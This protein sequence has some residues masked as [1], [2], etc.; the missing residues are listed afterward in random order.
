MD[1][2][3]PTPAEFEA[4]TQHVAWVRRLAYQLVRD[5]GVADDLAQDACLA[6]LEGRRREERAD[7]RGPLRDW[8][9]AV[10]R[11]G[12]RL[13]WRR[14]ERRNE[15][16]RA[17]AQL[18]SQPSTAELVERVA[19]HR[20][21]VDAVLALD[22]PYRA[23]L[24]QRYFEELSPTAIASRT[25]V[26]LATV[27][28]RLQRGIAQLRATLGGADGRASGLHALVPFLALPP[29]AP[30]PTALVVG[31]PL[32]GFFAMNAL[33]KL[34]LLAVAVVGGLVSFWPEEPPSAPATGPVVSDAATELKT[35]AVLEQGATR[36]TSRAEA[37]PMPTV[38]DVAA[39]PTVGIAASDAVVADAPRT[40]D[41][42][43][44]VLGARA[45]TLSGIALAFEP[46]DGGA[47]IE[48]MSG[49]GGTFALRGLQ[50]GG[51]I[52]AAGERYVTLFSAHASQQFGDAELVV[53]VAPRVVLGGCVVDVAGRP[54]ADALV[55]VRAPEGFRARFE[56]VL[57]HSGGLEVSTQTDDAGRFTLD[58]P[59]L[60]DGALVASH[61]RYVEARRPLP[62]TDQTELRLTLERPSLD[63]RTLVGVVLDA[64]GRPAAGARVVFG[65][66]GTSTAEDG[67]FGIDLDDER[68]PNRRASQM[69]FE[70]LRVVAIKPGHLPAQLE[71]ARDDATGQAV[72][73]AS[74]VLH[75]GGPP[76]EIVGRV[77]DSAGEPLPGVA[78]WVRDESVLEFGS[79]GPRSIEATVGDRAPNWE[80]PRT[81]SDGRFVLSGLVD[82][83]YVVAAHDA[84][85]LL[86][87]EREVRAGSSSVTLVLD[88]G[89][90]WRR[91]AGKVVDR[92]GRP[93]SGVHLRP[94]TDALFLR[95]QGR[96]VSTNHAGQP[97]STETDAEGKFELENMPRELVY[98]RID[99]DDVVSEDW[100]RR[101]EGGLAA[102]SNGRVEELEVV[103]RLRVR[104]QV[105][106][107]DPAEADAVR[108][109]DADG[110]A[111]VIN[112]IQAG[113][114]SEREVFPLV[115]GRSDVLTVDDSAA[116]LVL[117]REGQEVRR[118]P[119][120]LQRG[121]LNRVDA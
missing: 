13:E 53:V 120:A 32:I 36:T 100:G 41:V 97:R 69:G 117:E 119:L 112:L 45:E 102:L 109:L 47:P 94:M 4:L 31:T 23:T 22:E 14:A 74:L 59:L 110:A 1:H 26:P 30:L 49:Q 18:E 106:L 62:P 104:M 118:V 52:V 91:V 77:V 60:T 12:A 5:P 57:D 24:L 66:H 86:R 29:A 78:V 99:G 38:R 50:V 39:A 93:V 85:T 111:V 58:A 48:L 76:L 105:H 95:Y 17:A 80:S 56:R 10:L 67:S 9:A 79:R 34:A 28:T 7:E 73:P 103:V 108:V 55:Q 15:R 84:D 40:F 61:E 107:A 21:V 20:A 70:P 54:I 113:S 11:N 8:L 101:N 83:D 64:T 96:V 98:L 37:E 42:R 63:G 75:L 115:A 81:D 2:A 65:V 88:K 114:R 43:G 51:R 116:T 46:G 90:L 33:A 19:T 71:L 27:K 6:A 87:V 92:T 35:T 16:E 89:Q 121:E 72:L 44:V 3:Q 82:A 68:S 25:G